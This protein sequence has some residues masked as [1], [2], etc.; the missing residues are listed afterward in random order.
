V[1]V[2]GRGEIKEDGD[3]PPDDKELLR[4]DGL[5]GEWGRGENHRE[6]DESYADDVHDEVDLDE[7]RAEV[8]FGCDGGAEAGEDAKVTL[9][10]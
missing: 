2:V 8:A 5:E 7:F 3:G 10:C 9:H 1:E 6:N 4:G